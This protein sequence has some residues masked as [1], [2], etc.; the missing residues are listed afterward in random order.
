MKRIKHRAEGLARTALKSAFFMGCLAGPAHA[1]ITFQFHY[2]D[3]AGTGFFDPV[4]GTNRQAALNTAA[5]AF[6]DMFGSHFSATGTIVLDADVDDTPGILAGATS[7]L[8]N[9]GTP[10]FNLGEVVRTKLQTGVDLNGSRADGSLSINFNVPWDTDINS[11]PTPYSGQYDFYGTLFHEFTHTLGFSSGNISESGDPFRGTKEAGSW[12]SFASHLVDRRDV[13]IIDPTT[14]ALNQASWDVSSTGDFYPGNN[15]EGLFFDGPNAVAANN[16]SLVT[17][18]TPSP[19]EHGSSVS[20]I[21]PYYGSM[22]TPS[23]DTG[24]QPHDYS[25]IE[26][27]ILRDIGYVS[28]VPEPETYSML[29]AGLAVCGWIARR[30]QQ[31]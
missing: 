2:T 3:P 30:R 23:A 19:W 17:L 8:T 27:G 31:A 10:G 20:H 15:E 6:S 16:G 25:S 5:T 14:F 29:L 22:M 9:P 4:Y 24:L 1:A 18:Y 11:P 21:A 13:R 26:I 7:D 28:A 12:N